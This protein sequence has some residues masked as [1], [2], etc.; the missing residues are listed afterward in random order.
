MRSLQR[1]IITFMQFSKL[2]VLYW[3]KKG[4]AIAAQQ[5]DRARSRLRSLDC[6]NSASDIRT[7]E[8]IEN[9]NKAEKNGKK[10]K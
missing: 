3:T 4:R 2:D 7:T 9:K 8:A 10:G 1:I 5:I 6:R